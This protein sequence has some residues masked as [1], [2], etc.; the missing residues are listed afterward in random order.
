M[1]KSTPSLNAGGGAPLDAPLVGATRGSR[2]PA[3]LEAGKHCATALTAAFVAATLL[4]LI[5]FTGSAHAKPVHKLDSSLDGA[6][7]PAG[8][9]AGPGVM[10]VR[11]SDRLLYVIDG[12]SILKYDISDPQDPQLQNFSA[13]GS[14]AITE[15]GDPPAPLSL[16]NNADIAVDDSGGPADGTIYV[17][18][19]ASGFLPDGHTYAYSATG[20][21]LRE[22]KFKNGA[23]TGTANGLDVVA[24]GERAGDLYVARVA[25]FTDSDNNFLHY[26]V[27]GDGTLAYDEESSLRLAQLDGVALADAGETFFTNSTSGVVAHSIDGTELFNLDRPAGFTSRAAALAVD[28]ASGDVYTA[29]QPV[30]FG[31][32]TP[33]S[34][35]KYAGA[36]AEQ[37]GAK[38]DKFGADTLAVGVDSA[39][40]TIYGAD[41]VAH[42]IDIYVPG[43]VPDL[44]VGEAS[45][46]SLTTATLTGTVNP[47]GAPVTSCVFEYGTTTSYGQTADC[48]PASPGS[49]TEPVDVTGLAINLTGGTQYHYRL[50]VTNAD[51]TNVSADAT[52]FAPNLPEVTTGE[53]G[54]V[55]SR[56][57]SALLGGTVDP[58]KTPTKWWIEYG[59]ESDLSDAQSSPAG[60]DLNAGDGGDPVDVTHRVR[61]LEPETTYYYRVV[62]ATAA[63]SVEGDIRS[64]WMPAAPAPDPD[65]CA[66]AEFRRSGTPSAALPDCRAYERVSPAEKNGGSVVTG[67]DITTAD[68]DR[69]TYAAET[70]FAGQQSLGMIGTYRAERD[71]AG[72]SSE[73]IQP[74]VKW[75]GVGLSMG[76]WMPQTADAGLEDFFLKGENIALPG[77]DGAS[78][79][80]RGDDGEWNVLHG[81]EV[82]LD[83]TATREGWVAATVGEPLDVTEGPT[84]LPGTQG[85]YEFAEDGSEVHLLSVDENGDPIDDE[86]TSIQQYKGVVAD[87]SR[88]F[89][90]TSSASP[91]QRNRLWVRIGNEE[92]K[93]LTRSEVNPG[94]PPTTATFQGATP[95]GKHA[96]FISGDN[97]TE[98]SPAGTLMDLYRY[99][100]ETEE[101]TNLTTT[102]P[103]GANV[104]G[105]L[106]YSDDASI[107]YFE[108]SGNLTPG[109]SG[110]G[111]KI[112]RVN[113]DGLSLITDELDFAT[114]PGYLGP[115]TRYTTDDQRQ[116]QV[117]P[118]GRYLLFST[119]SD[120]G[121]FDADGYRE[122][123]RYDAAED[124]MQCV[125]CSLDGQAGG[126]AYLAQPALFRASPAFVAQ[127]GPRPRLTAD[128]KV[129]FA[130]PDPLVPQDSNNDFDVYMWDGEAKLISSGTS[131]SG[132][133]PTAM[134]EDASSIF[135]ISRGR[136][137][138]G[139][140]DNQVDLYVARVGGGLESQQQV[141]REEPPCQGPACRDDEPAPPEADNPATEQGGS[142][143]AANRC[144][145]E[146]RK[147]NRAERRTER[148]QRRALRKQQRAK[149]LKRKAKRA[150]GKRAHR[151]RKRARDARRQA[152]RLERKA[153]RA[154]KRE[155]RAA[156]R[157][158][159]C[160]NG[161]AK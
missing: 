42:E 5:A 83:A 109:A 152:R 43:T 14:P 130:T 77:V 127:F 150:H 98:D 92:T 153:T 161:G 108:A 82:W 25:G 93:E 17:S 159:R 157:A 88:V 54:P 44:T 76:N 30:F 56:T 128:G 86:H 112:Y 133:W 120:F 101:L 15:A 24:T 158:S 28:P 96:Y 85:I 111:P 1:R 139:D 39:S 90:Q 160:V 33:T 61:G 95:D 31:G 34:I 64:F 46:D 48:D 126:H 58:N 155:E 142:G 151:L 125:S 35:E 129:V 138:P 132:A 121:V 65:E 3:L 134:T 69:V 62:A 154:A 110:S 2:A 107:V 73:G 52:Y 4:F 29:G 100:V 149:K 37:P 141:P 51:G 55:G 140:D 22:L 103:N 147:L 71:L 18:T 115:A 99:D 53:R 74:P 68:G 57:G 19:G 97:L 40:D 106:G 87:G 38:L 114:K 78:L 104:R 117:S 80:H 45:F 118:D 13:L 27:Q 26:A 123:W 49:G 119:A 6:D 11:Q 23:L 63:G 21:F 156:R 50:K 89:F 10:E 148:V 67:Y 145:A 84:S 9:F 8:S 131:I 143:S 144:K 32:P 20:E 146:K 122:Y 75:S 47:L 72:W 12:D 136:L 36:D 81:G 124:R 66:N 70:G 16:G 59:T 79:A 94:Q 137:V 91:I 102:D 41:T 7:T 105:V 113:D 135:F 60:E 116:A